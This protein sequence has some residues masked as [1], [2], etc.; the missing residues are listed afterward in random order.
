MSKN[1]SI[2]KLP[3]LNNTN[4]AVIGLGYVGLPLIVSIARYFAENNIE[5]PDIIGFDI[6]DIKIKKLK[7]K[8]DPT[9]EINHDELKYFENIKFTSDNN[10]IRDADLFIVCV[11]TPINKN[12]QPNLDFLKSASSII[13]SELNKTESNINKKLIVFESTVYPGV[14]E[15]ICLPIIENTSK[16][17]YGKEFVVGYSPERINP[18]DKVNNISNITKLVSGSDDETLNWLSYF[19]SKVI[20]KQV[21]KVKNIKTAEAAKVVENIQRD[22]NI[23]LVNELSMLFEKLNLSTQ[24]VL[25]AAGSKW[26]FIRY[27]PGLVGGHCIGVD[28]Y[29]LTYK[30]NSVGYNAEV[31]LAGRRINDGMAEWIANFGLK[32]TL[33]SFNPLPKNIK[34]GIFGFTY[35]SNCNDIRNS[36]VFNL[37]KTLKESGCEIEVSDPC[38][39]EEEVLREYNIQLTNNENMTG[40]YH[41]VFISVA[42]NI[43]KDKN[44]EYWK[45][46][47]FEETIYVDIKNILPNF[48]G[49]FKI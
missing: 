27:S 38:A 48:R 34:V 29:Y 25:D 16:K 49:L 7:S 3:N 21:F 44:I 31:I 30:A 12:N 26:N 10:D 14:T 13:G 11:P 17:I 42:H 15:D 24:D 6:S 23:A 33:N 47:G 18:G 45:N 19:Y 37:Y 8:I 46:I 2:L 35:K 39:N 32:K 20:S 43:Y 4:I 41:L 1:D 5:N 28:P 40:K 36:K 22:L 9:R